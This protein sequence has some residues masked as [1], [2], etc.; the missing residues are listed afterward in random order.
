[1]ALLNPFGRGTA[2]YVSQCAPNDPV[3]EEFI[4]RLVYVASGRAG[5]FSLLDCPTPGGHVYYHPARGLL[6]VHNSAADG[7]KIVVRAGVLGPRAALLEP[8]YGATDPVRVPAGRFAVG[9]AF[10]V[11]RNGIRV[12]RAR[13]P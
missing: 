2:A 12:F 5:P 8:A 1:V 6:V 4:K 11:P 3:F 7:G 10:E 13:R 9:V